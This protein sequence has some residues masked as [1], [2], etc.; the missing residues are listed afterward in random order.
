MPE[1]SI[2]HG[3][4]EKLVNDARHVRRVVF[5][6]GQGVPEARELDGLDREAEHYVGYVDGAPVAVARTR[7][8]NVNRVEDDSYDLKIERVGVLPVYRAHRFGVEMM[9]FIL[10]QLPEQ[11]NVRNA[12]LES[13]KQALGFYSKLGFTAYGPIFEDAG[14]EHRKMYKPAQS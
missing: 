8:V 9:R 6:E 2:E 4:T 11:P 1:L 5:I 7:Q 14:I 13:Q 12:V 3:N 10:A